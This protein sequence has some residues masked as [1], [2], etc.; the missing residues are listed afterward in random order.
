MPGACPA[1]RWSLSTTQPG[2]ERLV[3]QA[4]IPVTDAQLGGRFFRTS[5]S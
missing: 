1:L 5:M 3:N 4:L 2:I